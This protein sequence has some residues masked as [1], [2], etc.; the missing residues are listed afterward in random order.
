MSL[1]FEKKPLLLGLSGGVAINAAIVAMNTLPGKGLQ[2]MGGVPL[3]TLGWVLIITSFLKNGTRASKYKNLLVGSS[4]G[5]YSMA[6][7]ARMMMDAG[8]SETP[9]TLTKMVFMVCWL[10]IGVLIGTKGEEVPEES[11]EEPSE[12]PS[13]IRALGLLPPLLVFLSMT[14]INKMERPRS[15]ASGPGLPLFMMAW[16]ILSLVN[17][18]KIEE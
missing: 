13:H 17:S 9:L 8:N 10:V 2:M 4:I 12:K 5:V 6:M 18:V 11:V 1:S 15:M 16:V 3:F 7:L 14:S